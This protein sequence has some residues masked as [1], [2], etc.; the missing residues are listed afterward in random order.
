[1]THFI[2]NIAATVADG[3]AVLPRAG[4]GDDARLAHALGEQDLADGVVD[5]VR[6]GVV[7]VFALEINFRAAEFLGEAFGK[8]KRRGA[9]DKFREVI[10]KLALKFR[11]V[12]RAEVF[13]LQLLQR[14]HQ[15]FRHITSAVGA[16][17]AC[18]VGQIQI[19]NCAHASFSR[20]GAKTQ[21]IF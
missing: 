11:V 21:R 6:A 9:A 10:R 3:D 2:P 17:V 12:L 5:L 1:M 14:V 7:Q 8:I 4:L 19:G 13:G 20:K 16:E 15:G 18:G